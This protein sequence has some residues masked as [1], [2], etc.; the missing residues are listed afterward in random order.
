MPIRVSP[1]WIALFRFETMNG[2]HKR[3]ASWCGGG[4]GMYPTVRR[5]A[6]HGTCT[7]LGQQANVSFC[8]VLART[9]DERCERVNSHGASRVARKNIG[10]QG[11]YVRG[12]ERRLPCRMTRI[13][14][15]TSGNVSPQP[16]VHEPTSHVVNGMDGKVSRIRRGRTYTKRGGRV[17]VV[18]VER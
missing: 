2:E 6:V 18:D 1:S 7:R 16:R 10:Y 15:R 4:T 9:N 3:G 8:S 11:T 14:C 13:T 12:P 5:S 17:D